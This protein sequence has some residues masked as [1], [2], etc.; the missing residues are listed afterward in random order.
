LAMLGRDR[1]MI[2]KRWLVG[3]FIGSLYLNLNHRLT[4]L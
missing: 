3:L 1:S 4:R 2:M